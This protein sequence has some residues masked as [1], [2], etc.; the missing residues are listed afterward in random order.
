MWFGAFLICFLSVAT[1]IAVDILNWPIQLIALIVIYFADFAIARVLRDD[2]LRDK[3]EGELLIAVIVLVGL[4]FWGIG[5]VKGLDF[6]FNIDLTQIAK[7]YE[8]HVKSIAMIVTMIAGFLI[9]KLE[10]IGDEPK[11]EV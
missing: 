1:I 9:G 3:L 8:G 10:M 7:P 6:F 11:S 4:V 2:I 5:T